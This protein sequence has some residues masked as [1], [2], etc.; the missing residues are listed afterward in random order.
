MEENKIKNTDV[1]ELRVVARKIWDN[2]KVFYKVLPIVFVL[3]CIFILGMPRTYSTQAKLAPEMGNSLSGGTLGSLAASFGFDIDEMQT[4]DA[5]TPLLYP[6]LM[7][8]NGFV[9]SL[10]NIKVV[11]ADG[12][13]N[14][15]YYDYLKTKQKPNIW[16]IPITKIRKLLNSDDAKATGSSKGFDPY[17]LSKKDNEIAGSVKSCIKLS[18]DKKTGVITITTKAQDAL[19]CKTIA[20][21]LCGR[22][23]TF[24]T[25]YRTKKARNDYE[26]YKELT[27]EAKQD[28]E[29]ARQRYASTSDANTRV[30][31]KSVELMMEDMENDMQLKFNTYT[32]ISSQMQAAKAKVQERTP[33]FTVLQGAAVPVKASSPKRMIFVASML[34]LAFF[35]TSL[36]LA[37]K[38]LHFTF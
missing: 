20:D 33:A 37:R 1:I 7:D 15:S 34:F 23:Q 4:S 29:R 22:L 21:S 12:E 8:D 31:L 27:R 16:L 6:D 26:Y 24:I 14:T 17:Y 10:F 11:S 3:S 28:Y 38:E 18:V 13:I 5:I 32:T 9:T 25:D 36:Y 30:A 35:I 2:R 19:I